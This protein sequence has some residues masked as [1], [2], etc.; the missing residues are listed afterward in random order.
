[1][2]SQPFV[3]AAHQGLRVPPEARAEGDVGIEQLGFLEKGFDDE[4]ARQRLAHDGSLAVA[5]DVLAD[6]WHELVGLF[7]RR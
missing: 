4:K 1:L 2:C 5:A 6:R 7:A 3:G